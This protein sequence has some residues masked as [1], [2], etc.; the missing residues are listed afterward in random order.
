MRKLDKQILAHVSDPAWRAVKRLAL[1]KQLG[2][3]KKHLDDFHGAVDRLIADGRIREG[4]QGRLHIRSGAAGLIAGIVKRTAGGSGFLIPHDP[5]PSLGGS[6]VFIAARDMRDAHTG[7]EVLVQLTGRKRSGGRRCGCIEQ[8]LE[9]A[10]TTFVGTYFERAG[11]GFVR[12][13]G[14]I[15]VEP[16]HLGDP[17]AKGA[18]PN[19]KVVIDILRFPSHLHTGEAVLTK[20]LGP[21]GAPGV[22]TAAII[23]EFGLPDEFPTGVI[24]DARR[25]ARNFDESSLSG[26]RDLTQETIIT[27][28]PVDARD[29]DDAISLK[30]RRNGHWLLGVHIADVAHFVP[31][32]SPVDVEAK[33]RGNS[34]YL[35]QRVLPMLPE[36]ISNGVASLQ[37]GRVRYAKSIFIEFTPDGIPVH[38]EFD[39]TAI[40]VT[41]RFAYEEV[42]PVI[43]EPDRHRGSVGARIL[44]LLGRMYALAMILRK[45]RFARGA[46]EL[47][48][49]EISIDVNDDGLVIGAHEAPHDES[50]QIIE[51]F[52]LAANIAIAREMADRSVPFLRR[53]HADPDHPKLRAFAEFSRALGFKLEKYQ[54]RPDLQQLLDSARGTPQ[55]HAVNFALLRSM[56]QAEYRPLDTGHYALAEDD[57]CH[58]TSP[59][60][61]Y[62]DLTLQRIIGDLTEGRRRHFTSEEELLKLGKHCSLTERRAEKAE[63]ELTRLKL[64]RFMSE[65]KGRQLD[66]VITGVQSFGFFCRGLEIPAEGL[67][68]LGTLDHD[69]YHFDATAHLLSGHRDG[70]R[71]QLGDRVRV[72]IA[73]VD[74]DRRELDYR[75]VEKSEN[76]ARSRT[77][78]ST[79]P[80][81][82]AKRK[83]AARK[84]AK[85]ATKKKKTRSKSG[86]TKT[87]RRRR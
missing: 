63:R 12:V 61:R 14:T 75:F 33:K 62:P 24:E 65:H 87:T 22:D 15:L 44:A 82:S 47:C 54:S 6:D 4:R 38:T 67:V 57:Y 8:V 80:R 30:R 55:E 3:K 18:R 68:H 5:V 74:L 76:T 78:T 1:A 50:H 83:S 37:Q 56:K 70:N 17:G 72:E 39:G 71:F 35:P 28:D 9:R 10:R 36:V 43:R 41:R 26:R 16:I 21:R 49:P 25:Q 86:R 2:L 53:T 60:R 42:M 59:I 77:K 34:V 84:S 32:G 52:M 48:L 23:H 51:E 64:L 7:D 13:D 29:F 79:L 85:K 45:R 11:Q 40:R 73:R 81:Q 69:N 46:L 20:V 27:I 66:A 19:D 31:Q 58:F